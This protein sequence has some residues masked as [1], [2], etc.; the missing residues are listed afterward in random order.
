MSPR[1]APRGVVVVA[2]RRDRR[3]FTRYDHDHVRFVLLPRQ[4]RLGTKRC[5]YSR[6]RAVA[7][8]PDGR[9]LATGSTDATVRLWDLASGQTTTTLSPH[10]GYVVSVAFSPNGRILASASLDNT[11]RL[12]DPA[13]GQ[14]TATLFGHADFVTAVAFSPDGHTLASGSRDKTVRLWTLG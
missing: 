6:I 12:W 10:G 8:S 7:F 9:T 13:T 2:D 3:R 11:V 5:S 4:T 1:R 14:A